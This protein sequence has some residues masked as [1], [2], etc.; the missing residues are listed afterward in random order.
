MSSIAYPLGLPPIT[1]DPVDPSADPSKYPK[2]AIPGAT[3]PP[4]TPVPSLPAAPVTNPAPTPASAVPPAQQL[5]L[6]PQLPQ[7]PANAPPANLDAQYNAEQA[8]LAFEI[9]QRYN[10]VLKQLGYLD[11]GT[12]QFVMGRVETEANRQRDELRRSMGL[13]GE[14]QTKQR[15]LEGTLFSGRRGTEQ[16]RAEHPFVQGLADLDINVP[17]QLTDLYE[18]GGN[19]V[20]EYTNRLNLLLADAA[21]RQAASALTSAYPDTGAPP[22]G[23]APPTD[24]LPP[25]TET[26]SPLLQPAL[27]P[28]PSRPTGLQEFG[29]YGY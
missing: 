29:Q 12:G 27:P 16:A 5:A 18:T 24:T 13:A 25:P 17:Q 23:T 20:T 15:Q 8:Q 22:P 4:V 11:P 21:R 7:H 19:L 3:P 28:P 10:D 26:P 14:E 1:T 6:N 9:S 2:Y